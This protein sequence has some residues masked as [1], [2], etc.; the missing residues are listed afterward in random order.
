MSFLFID[1]LNMKEKKTDNSISILENFFGIEVPRGTSEALSRYCSLILEW[2]GFAG[3]V[4]RN[5]ASMLDEH[6]ADSLSL[7]PYLL[8]R[9]DCSP[10]CLDIGSGA[11]FPAIPIALIHNEL[12]IH[13]WES[14]NKKAS[15]L[16]KATAELGLFQCEV[17]NGRFDAS[18]YSPTPDYILSR[19]A[20]PAGKLMPLLAPMIATGAKLLY[21]GRWNIDTPGFSQRFVLDEF[22][23]SGLRRSRL[24]VVTASET[25]SQGST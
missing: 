7:A 21:Q 10:L 13:H 14:N 15:F 22:D 23:R 11:G 9:A 5:D 12:Q 1:T 19:A 6:V 20:A 4:S 2:N 18:N 24:S 8:K 25:E 3:L 17:K 16:K